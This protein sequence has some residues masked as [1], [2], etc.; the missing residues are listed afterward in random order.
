MV[1]RPGE[2]LMHIK[3]AG[4]AAPT[5]DRASL[6][7]EGAMLADSG[8]LASHHRRCDEIFSAARQAANA[9]RWAELSR[10]LNE[11]R[12]AVLAHFRYEEEHIFPLY[13][14]AHDDEGGTE[15]L[16]AQH[17]DMRGMLWILAS[18]H[19]ED[20]APRL[21]A[22]LAA[23]QEAFDAHAAEEERRMYPVFERML[24]GRA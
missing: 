19:P 14:Q 5:M 17:D 1:R 12:E 10:R 18:F 20:D 21:R 9:A 15:W 3:E 16:C 7:K 24:G 6:A 23:L 22:E 8:T 2:G 13:E 4:S 11:L